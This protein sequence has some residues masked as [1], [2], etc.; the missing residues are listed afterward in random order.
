MHDKDAKATVLA[1]L[2][3]ASL[4][5]LVAG[6]KLAMAIEGTGGMQPPRRFWY[7]EKSR[8]TQGHTTVIVLSP[9]LVKFRP[10]RAAVLW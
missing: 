7:P 5:L 10:K 8:E 3:A 6:T 9:A 4:R 1:S 2:V